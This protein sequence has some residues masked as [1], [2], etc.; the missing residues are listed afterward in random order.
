MARFTAKVT[1]LLAK[2]RL[3]PVFIAGVAG[4]VIMEIVALSPSSLEE[5][6]SRSAAVDPESLM[7]NEDVTLATG[8]PKDRVPEY[9]IDQFQY[10][11]T[12]GTEKQWK[13]VADKAHLYNIERIVHSR[14]VRAYLYDPDGKIT[15]VTGREAKYF[16]NGRDL[17]IFGNVHTVFPDGFELRSEYLRYRPN[18]RKIEIPTQYLV[19][20]D[21]TEKDGTRTQT[22]SQGL[23]YPMAK[24]QITLPQDVKLTFTKA[25]GNVTGGGDEGPTVVESDRA[26]LHRDKQIAYFTMNPKR[27]LEK[28]FVVITQ[29]T[30]V[31]KARRGEMHYGATDKLLQYMTVYE[32]VLI[33][34]TAAQVKKRVEASGQPE[35]EGPTLKYATGGRADFDA[36]SDVIRLTEFPQAYQDNDTVTG[37]V[38]ILHRDTD[39]VE[40]EHSNAFSQGT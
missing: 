28:S 15:V 32:D 14:Q 23:D 31:T 16:M 7:D 8:I 26:V 34:D 20:G 21:G 18:E 40:V 17:E 6:G 30:M 4:L 2:S 25:K 13:L 24:S 36:Q 35:K 22:V 9:S 33:R 38:I 11:S 37:D 12:H 3:K 29:P 19:L 10:V 27:A 5:G 1:R 39:L